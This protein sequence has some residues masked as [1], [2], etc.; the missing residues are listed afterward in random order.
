[1]LT[2]LLDGD[3]FAFQIASSAEVATH[4]G[5]DFWTLHADAME[6]K[7]RLDDYIERM[8]VDLEADELVICLSDRSGNFR[9][10][11]LPT[12]KA[13]RISK[14]KPMIL[15]ELR[16]YLITH[17]KTYVKPNLEA[18]DVLGILM[19]SKTLIKGDKIIVSID[20]DL[21]SIP[22]K[23]Y[24]M[25]HPENG[26]FEVTTEE[27]DRWHMIQTLIG[28]ATDGYSGCPGVG[29]KTAEKILAEAPTFT[30]P[31]M[32]PLVVET[33]EKKGM[34]KEE[35]LLMAQVARILRKEDYDFKRKEVRLWQPTV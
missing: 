18:D 21:K 15:M 2:L 30:Y 4:W 12:Y 31:D 23:H 13:N 22:G 17:Y 10:D 3:I 34:G 14:R 20:K 25:N 7:L 35:A 5:N 1:M 6:A 11:I 33:Y 28:D 26:V 29:M 27:A 19:T 32:W 24:Q 8:R 16:E 9:K